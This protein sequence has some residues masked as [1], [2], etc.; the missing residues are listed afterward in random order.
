M[1]QL[2]REKSGKFIA[3]LRHEKELTPINQ[4]QK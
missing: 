4:P 2:D 1:Y 3:Q